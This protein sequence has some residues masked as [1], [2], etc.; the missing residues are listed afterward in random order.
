MNVEADR[1]A[2]LPGVSAA[3]FPPRV[4]FDSHA[5][6]RRARL[7]AAL[8]D[9]AQ[10]ALVA[11]VDWLFLHFPHTHVPFFDRAH[12]LQILTLLNVLM[13]AYLA[14]ARTLPRW[15]AKRVAVTWNAAERSRFETVIN[16]R[17]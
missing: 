6:M 2:L 9:S 14:L 3:G 8:V 16:A 4:V 1:E 11:G 10:L 5:A 15:R 13:V 7:R 12:S 17:R